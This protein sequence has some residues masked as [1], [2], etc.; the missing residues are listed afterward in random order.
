MI[1]VVL[2]LRKS[3]FHSQMGAQ[4]GIEPG[5]SRTQSEN[6]ATRPLSPQPPRHFPELLAWWWAFSSVVERPFCI[7]KVEGSNPSSSITFSVARTKEHPWQDSNLQPPDPWSGALPLSHTDTTALVQV[8]KWWWWWGVAVPARWATEW[9]KCTGS[10][11]R[12]GDLTRVGR[13]S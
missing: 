5:T 6:H 2:R 3:T 10:R 1:A 12:T 4:P 9:E 8:C 11:D 13:A 7:R